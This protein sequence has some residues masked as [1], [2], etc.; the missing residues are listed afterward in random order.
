MN[1]YATIAK[2]HL[3][4]ITSTINKNK[5]TLKPI[6]NRH[7]LIWN[8]EKIFNSNESLFIIPIRIKFLWIVFSQ[9]H[10]SGINIVGS[11]FQNLKFLT[12]TRIHIFSSETDLQA[13]NSKYRNR[14]KRTIV[15]HRRCILGGNAAS[16]HRRELEAKNY[17][18]NNK[19]A[20]ISVF[21][22]QIL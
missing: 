20:K 4:W 15:P 18:G 10:K 14:K 21:Q 9:V 1:I 8:I 11:D 16:Q 19:R 17:R 6:E 7:T 12:Q 3:E 2:K 13:S 5:T 22:Q